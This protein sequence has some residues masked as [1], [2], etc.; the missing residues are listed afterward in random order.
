MEKNILQRLQMVRLRDILHVFIF[1]VAI[2]PSVIYRKRHGKLWLVSEC[3]NE[4]RDNGYW[5]FRYISENHP[6]QDAVYAI[7][8]K[9]PDFEKVSSLGKT[10]QYGSLMHW[11]TYLACDIRIS[12]H[13]AGNPN[14]AVC[15]VLERMKIVRKK[16]VFLQHGIAKD[17][18]PYVHA[19]NANFSM[20]AT[21]VRREYE[22]IRDTFGYRDGVV[23]QTGLCRF[24]DLQDCSDGSL[25]LIMPT[26]R[27]WIAN[28]DYISKHNGECGDFSQTEYFKK[29]NSLL[30]SAE[31]KELLHATGKRAVFYQHR[32]MQRFTSNFHSQ[33]PEIEIC[34][35]PDDA[36]ELLKKA[37]LLIT[38]YSSVAMD[39]A[40]MG[41]PV[42]YYQF[43]YGKF[44]RN[45]LGE[46]YYSYQKDGFGPVVPDED[47]VIREVG[48]TVSMR[49]KT[50]PMY[51]QRADKFF[52][53]KDRD[54]CMRTYKAVMRLSCTEQEPDRM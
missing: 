40:F 33:C 34:T 46:G 51:A 20:F 31:F 48:M 12:T 5:F 3:S 45:H 10:V 26:W 25:I 17:D 22:Y 30:H 19:G 14:S 13:K 1:V 37:S 27:Q 41:K 29:W 28:P 49:M 53:L 8:H 11:I 9:S 35:F 42:V 21:S 18:L 16:T 52:D 4:A 23:V 2:I 43:D 54:N 24:D 32:N 15:Y 44:R 50:L 7:S 6:E 39:F 36:H 47:G 38:D